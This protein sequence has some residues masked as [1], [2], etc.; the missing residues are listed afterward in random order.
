[1]EKAGIEV[2]HFDVMDN[3]FVPNLTF[4][5][6]FVSDLRKH[7][8]LFFDVHLMIHKPEVHFRHYLEA[9]ADLIVIHYEAVDPSQIRK[10]SEEI[11][12]KGK[13]F[14]ISIKPA[15]P[16]NVLLPFLEYLDLILIMT[17]EPGFGGQKLIEP[18]VEK[19]AELKKMIHD[20]SLKIILQVDGGVDK[21]N[22]ERIYHRGA[23]WF[24]VGSAFFKEPDFTFFQKL[25][26][27]IQTNVTI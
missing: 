25:L 13:K 21:D 3:H 22:L 9:G 1:M 8:A 6:K 2:I 24:V 23:D 5:H 11:R 12:K 14:G 27:R 4:G 26:K 19:V 20:S 18:C 7:S 16:V 10:V 17:V 15:T